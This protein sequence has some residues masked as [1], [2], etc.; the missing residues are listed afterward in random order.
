MSRRLLV[1]TNRCSGQETVKRALKGIA[2]FGEMTLDPGG[3]SQSVTYPREEQ[4]YFIEEGSGELQYAGGTYPVRRN[5]FMYLAAGSG[6][7]LKNSGS[8]PLRAIVMGFKLPASA[9]DDQPSKPPIA[10]TDDVKKQLVGG[11]PASTLYQLMI[12]DVTSTRDKIAAAHVVTSLFMMEIAPGWHELSASPRAR[13]G[14]LSAARW[15]RRHGRRRWNGWCGRPASGQTRRCIFH[16]AKRDCR[17]LQQ[18][19][20]GRS[21]SA[22][23]GGAIV[24]SLCWEELNAF[25]RQPQH[26]LH[27]LARIGDAIRLDQK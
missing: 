23:P 24:V 4:I 12:G 11:H 20:A 25:P 7:G 8:A 5:D 15:N 17:V 13:R 3:A 14:N 1:I 16:P 18:Q 10:N 9:K 26:L 21:E 19:C 2:R 27:D 22:Y 6:Q